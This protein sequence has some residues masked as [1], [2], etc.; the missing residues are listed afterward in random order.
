MEP[1]AG[2]GH[3]PFAVAETV[4]ARIGAEVVVLDRSAHNP[5][6]QQPDEFNALLRRV[7]S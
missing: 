2:P 6:L 4:D 1:T 7:W 3:A 5:Q